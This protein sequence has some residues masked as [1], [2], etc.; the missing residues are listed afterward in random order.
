MVLSGNRKATYHHAL[1]V[2]NQTV[3]RGVVNVAIKNS[4]TFSYSL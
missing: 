1:F 3:T 4:K 2:Y